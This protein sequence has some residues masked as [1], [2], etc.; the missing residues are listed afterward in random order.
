MAPIVENQDVSKYS[1]SQAHETSTRAQT[2]QQRVQTGWLDRISVLRTLGNSLTFQL[3][4]GVRFLHE[5]RVTHLDLKPA[6]MVITATKQLQLIDF[7]SVLISELESWVAD[8]N[9]EILNPAYMC[10][11]S[12][13]YHHNITGKAFARM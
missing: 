12:K 6:V 1:I 7:V 8:R 13:L 10:I 4:D 11:S 9:E 3:L 2:P 5:H